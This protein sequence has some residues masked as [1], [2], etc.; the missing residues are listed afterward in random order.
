MHSN[1]EISETSHRL[2][3]ESKTK[4]MCVSRW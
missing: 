3:E 4:K 1:V 2:L